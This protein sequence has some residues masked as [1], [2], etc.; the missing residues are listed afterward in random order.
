MSAAMLTWT[1]HSYSVRKLHSACK[2]QINDLHMVMPAWTAAS[3]MK[4]LAKY[5]RLKLGKC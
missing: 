2:A 5:Y 4:A 3:M 1:T